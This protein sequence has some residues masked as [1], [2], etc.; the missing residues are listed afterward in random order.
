M[1]TTIGSLLLLL[2]AGCAARNPNWQQDFV[3]GV[4]QNQRLQGGPDLWNRMPQVNT[5]RQCNTSCYSAGGQVYCN[6]TCR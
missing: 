6:E 3:R 2:L 1:K 4:E 5:G